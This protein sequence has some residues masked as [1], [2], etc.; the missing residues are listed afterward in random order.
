[1]TT[2]WTS[3][4]TRATTAAA[5]AVAALFA[6][7]LAAKPDP[8][9]EA[10]RRVESAARGQKVYFNA[11]AGD[12]AINQYIDWAAQEVERRHGVT[13]VHVKVADISAAVAR[14]LAER[15]AGRTVKGSVDLLWIN[16]ENFASLKS[17]GLL[18]GPWA[19]EV[20]N[21]DLLDRSD[22]TLSVD[23]TIPTG[24]YELPWGGARFTLFYDAAAVRGVAPGDP[25]ALLAWI[26]AHPGRFT[27]PQPPDFIGTSFLKQ[28]LLLLTASPQRLR[29][30]V[31][32]DFDV[33]TQPLWTWLD[34]AHPHLW[35]SGQLFPRSAPEQRRLLGDGEIDWMLSFNP[36]EAARAIRQ[37][38][39]P[40]SIRGLQFR[41]GAL[42]NSHFLAI[43]FN[44]SARE[45][46]LVVANF[47]ISAEAQARKAD[48]AVWGDPTVLDLDRVSAEERRRFRSANRSPA[49]PL[50]HAPALMEP[51]PS[52]TSAL[53][54]AWAKRYGA[55]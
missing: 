25:R 5:I 32:E 9:S 44:A 24:G 16:G 26:G 27:Y 21:A 20:P 38:E 28:L 49:K 50:A 41:A 33:V 51:H 48:D 31:A 47:L 19:E 54:R 14:I 23:F 3:A 17:A 11:W 55:Q 29:T 18:Y 8:A 30:P 22:P 10:W 12:A 37:G 35:R 42:S 2:P 1:M 43:P 52:W 6:S 7:G 53:E 36:A 34:R 13:V 4:V 15:G 39:L 40:E 46:A 45:G